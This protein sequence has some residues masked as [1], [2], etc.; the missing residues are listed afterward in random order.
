MHIDLSALG[1]TQEELQKRVV[2]QICETLM[3]SER[4]DDEGNSWYGD[5]EFKRD[6]DKQIKARIEE[7]INTLAEKHVLPKVSQ[8]IEGLTLQQTTQWGEKRGEPVSFV[9]YLT[10]RA[11]DYMQE[12]VNYEGKGK[13]DT[14]SISWSGTQTRITYLIHQHL[15]YSIE[16]AMK[17]AL[18]V[19]TGEIAK[20]IHETAKIKLNEIS[21]TLKVSVSTK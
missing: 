9:E 12:K 5:S 13:N 7:T 16:T 3:H 6:L 15:H 14:G 10:K 4:G 1:F 19:A 20:G 2:D 8:Y 21:E 11:E 17:N 18:K